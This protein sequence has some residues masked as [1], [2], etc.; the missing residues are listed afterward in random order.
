MASNNFSCKDCEFHQTLRRHYKLVSDYTNVSCIFEEESEDVEGERKVIRYLVD[1]V[2]E[3]F[4]VCYQQL[5][6]AEIQGLI[7]GFS[8]MLMIL[9]VFVAVYF[10]YGWALRAYMYSKGL[11][12]CFSTDDSDED[13][14][15]V[16]DAFVSYSH[17]VIIQGNIPYSIF[18]WFVFL[19]F[20]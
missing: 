6:A 13:G 17:K 8:I 14:E 1:K 11:G 5:V 19:I 7:I 20:W 4:Q 9:V 2:P 18:W 15:K 10:R 12:C 3:K 16:Y